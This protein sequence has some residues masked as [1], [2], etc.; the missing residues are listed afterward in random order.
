MKKSIIQ[1]AQT[2]L[3]AKGL[4]NGDPDGDIGEGTIRAVNRVPGLDPAWTTTMKLTGFIQLLC[5]ENGFDPYGV[6]G[7]WGHNTEYAYN[8]LVF[9][10][11]NGRAPDPWR[12]EDRTPVNPNHWPVQYTPEFDA[13]YG[14]KGTNQARIDLPYPHRIAWDPGK[15]ILSFSCHAKVHD[16]LKRVLT[17][18]VEHYGIEEIKRLKLDYWGGCYNERPIRGG[19]RWSMHSWAIAIDYDPE[20]NRLDWGRDRATFARPE[21]DK[22]WEFW[23]EEGWVSLGRD[24]NYD[25]MHVQAAKI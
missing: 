24:R 22:W 20:R 6:D 5:L 23:E 10:R 19:T 4:Y 21:Y 8:Q 7:K 18:V 11:Q 17:K 25:W 9:L 13:F 3:K 2:E 14:P 16:S 15:T 12:P 1:F